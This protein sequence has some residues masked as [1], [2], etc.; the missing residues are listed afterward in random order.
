MTQDI[1]TEVSDGIGW[2]TFNR[3][4]KHNALTL[5]MRIGIAQALKQMAEDRTV[6][7]IVLKGA[8]DKAFMAG[9]DIAE[10]DSAPDGVSED[11]ARAL[12]AEAYRILEKPLIAM[13]RGYCLGAGMA[14][15]LRA[16]FRIAASDAQFA[17]PAAKRGIGYPFPLV[18]DL[19][20]LIGPARARL[21]LY[22]GRRFSAEQALSFKLI[23]EVV[24]PD[25]LDA[26]V[27][28][29][30]AEIA[31]NAPLSIRATHTSIEQVLKPHGDRDMALVQTRIDEARNS[32]DF[33]ESTKAFLEKRKPVFKGS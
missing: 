23:E 29:Y 12:E 21:M 33:R 32:D 20:T 25:E 8:G 13:I 4:D 16:D 28:S 3:P 26:V 24:A 2:I 19:V 17:I 31:G 10:F 30:A 7:V 15:A 6:R 9:A 14:T 22:T 5:A 18:E 1:L 27:T 11:E